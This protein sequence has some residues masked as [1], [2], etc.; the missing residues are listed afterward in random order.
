MSHPSTRRIGVGELVAARDLETINGDAVAVPD[1]DHV[2]HL[3]LRRFAGCP[4]CNLHLQSVVRRHDDIVAAGVREVVV[5]HSR[6]DDLREHAAHLPFAV[7]ADPAKRLYAEFGAESSPRALLDPR[8]W[9]PI[10]RAVTHSLRGIL[11]GRHPSP[12]LRPAGGRY[13]LPADLL[14]DT[15]GRVLARKYGEHAYDRWSVDELLSMARSR[16]SWH[17]GCEGAADSARPR[18]RRSGREYERPGVLGFGLFAPLAR[19]ERPQDFRPRAVAPRR[20][21]VVGH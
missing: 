9:L 5:F 14:I 11:R 12:S 6:V 7:V 17:G 13:G 15:D 16:A 18:G 10:V 19:R 2:V 8:A 4:V 1:P 21:A 3:Q 20:Q